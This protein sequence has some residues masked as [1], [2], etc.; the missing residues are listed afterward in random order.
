MKKIIAS[1]CLFAGFIA[2]CSQGIE[3]KAAEGNTYVV[4]KTINLVTSSVSDSAINDNNY[5]FDMSTLYNNRGV[6]TN[7]IN[8]NVEKMH[9]YSSKY[10]EFIKKYSANCG[11]DGNYSD[12]T[13]QVGLNTKMGYSEKI[14]TNTYQQYYSY[15]YSEVTKTESLNNT[16]GLYSMYSQDFISRVTS[17]CNTDNFDGFKSIFVDYGTHFITKAIFG[18]SIEKNAWMM[19]NSVDITNITSTSFETQLDSANSEANLSAQ[20][21]TLK[22][23]YTCTVEASSYYKEIHGL[24]PTNDSMYK[25]IWEYFDSSIKDKMEINFKKYAID[26]AKKKNCFVGQ[27]IS[28][29]HEEWYKINGGVDK[30]GKC[31]IKLEQSLKKYTSSILVTMTY[32][33]RQK[34]KGYS[35]I[36]AFAGNES[37]RDKDKQLHNSSDLGYAKSS[38]YSAAKYE[39]TV[40]C[41]DLDK[42]LWIMFAASGSGSDEWRILD[43]DIKLEYIL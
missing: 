20:L 12:Y 36:Y 4:G 11:V 3:L 17:A 16:S 31:P 35:Y 24:I 15:L 27:S 2:I 1:I 6:I 38:S 29:Y 33:V 19:A 23:N 14:K 25:P 9:S 32:N 34:D 40:N 7:N 18:T 21:N 10:N 39:F 42:Y 43:L 5:I 30:N 37:S 13:F 22:S 28:D 26:E 8:N 41:S